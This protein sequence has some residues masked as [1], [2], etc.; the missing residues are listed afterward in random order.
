MDQSTA[1]GQA[2]APAATHDD[3]TPRDRATSAPEHPARLPGFHR[4]GVTERLQLLRSRGLLTQAD[5]RALTSGTQRLEPAQADK[6]IENVIGVMGLPVGLGLNFLINGK[7]Y[8]VPLVVVAGRTAEPPDEQA[9]ATTAVPITAAASSRSPMRRRA[10]M[11]PPGR[12]L[13]A[14]PRRPARRSGC[15]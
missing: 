2:D 6:M 5:H 9:D 1:I 15:R 12:G 3:D 11:A 4:L 7:D 10:L 13:P 8:V 14:P